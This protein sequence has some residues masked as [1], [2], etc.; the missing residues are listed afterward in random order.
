[1]VLEAGTNLRKPCPTYEVLVRAGGGIT[2]FSLISYL[3]CSTCGDS[4]GGSQSQLKLL[5]PLGVCV[6]I[7]LALLHP[8]SVWRSLLLILSTVFGIAF[9][10]VTQLVGVAPCPLCWAIWA[11]LG[12]LFVELVLA[13][14]SLASLGTLAILTTAISVLVMSRSSDARSQTQTF[15]SAMGLNRQTIAPGTYLGTHELWKESDAVVIATRCPDC[16][17]PTVVQVLSKMALEGKK[18]VVAVPPHLETPL[19]AQ[20]YKTV[21]LP[22]EFVRDPR[23]A[24]E[25]MPTIIVHE[26]GVVTWAGS[27]TEVGK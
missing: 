12:L 10:S 15:A 18:V 6:G 14:R 25:A 8:C 26:Q 27:I 16:W 22:A 3:G 24:L 5:A 17:T 7:A 4:I 1:M 9:L 20:G 2:V 11:T 13:N 19:W 23:I 21:V